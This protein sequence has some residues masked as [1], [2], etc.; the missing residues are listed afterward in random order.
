M[1]SG[2]PIASAV[3]SLKPEGR[4]NRLGILLGPRRR[5]TDVCRKP[6]RLRLLRLLI[7]RMAISDAWTRR[8]SARQ[9]GR[10]ECQKTRLTIRPVWRYLCENRTAQELQPHGTGKFRLGRPRM[11]HEDREGF[12]H[13]GGCKFNQPH[14]T[15]GG[16]ASPRG[17]PSWKGMILAK[18]G[19]KNTSRQAAQVTKPA[20]RPSIP[21]S[22]GQRF[23][24][25]CSSIHARP[26]VFPEEKSRRCGASDDLLPAGDR[27]ALCNSH[28]LCFPFVMSLWSCDESQF[29]KG[30]RLCDVFF[31]GRRSSRQQ[32]ATRKG[33]RA[34]H[35]LPS[36]LPTI[37]GGYCGSRCSNSGDCLV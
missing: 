31:P 19:R 21:G 33:I 28:V 11:S 20:R 27:A 30:G 3:A 2:S 1:S 15:Y 8:S 10:P 25:A 24:G 29:P 26:P 16:C 34:G 4:R 6:K 22:F 13:C 17:S 14:Y 12:V 37:I 36:R 32:D 18:C 9:R 23:Q 5:L 35:P 7:H